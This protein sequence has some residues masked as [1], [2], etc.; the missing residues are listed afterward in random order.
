MGKNHKNHLLKN[1]NSKIQNLLNF[2]NVKLGEIE[3]FTSFPNIIFAKFYLYRKA[4]KFLFSSLFLMEKGLFA[5]LRN[6]RGLLKIPFLFLFFSSS[7][8]Q[9][10]EAAPWQP[11]RHVLPPPFRADET[12]QRRA[13]LSLSR[14]HPLTLPLPLSDPLQVQNPSS[15]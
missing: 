7:S 10:D 6:S 11:P 3:N 12:P 8:G 9:K 15:P 4:P 2:G 14:T 1:Q 5:N 13:A